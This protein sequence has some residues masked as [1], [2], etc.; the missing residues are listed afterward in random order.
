MEVKVHSFL[1]LFLPHFFLCQIVACGVH[2]RSRTVGIRFPFTP[3]QDERN[4][5]LSLLLL[6]VVEVGL[7]I[8]SKSEVSKSSLFDLPWKSN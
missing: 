3:E 6:L 5:S 1:V 8:C 2:R 7:P 4:S